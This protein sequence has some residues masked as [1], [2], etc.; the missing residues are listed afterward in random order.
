MSLAWR[1]GIRLRKSTFIGRECMIGHGFLVGNHT[2]I[3]ASDIGDRV[4]IDDGC[5]INNC[6]ISSCARIYR[7]VS[8]LDVD[9]ESYS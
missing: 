6:N 3:L 7:N 8:L 9:I 5:V 1:I 2:K 4:I